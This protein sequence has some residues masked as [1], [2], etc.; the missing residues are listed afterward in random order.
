MIHKQ[1]IERKNKIQKIISRG[2]FIIRHKNILEIGS[3]TVTAFLEMAFNFLLG[4][5]GLIASE[6]LR[7]MVEEFK[8][9]LK[10]NSVFCV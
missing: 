5:G 3:D 9:R 10:I 8:D 2:Y 6:K 4:K 1:T 7:F